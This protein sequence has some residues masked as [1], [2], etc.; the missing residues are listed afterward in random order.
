[1]GGALGGG[2][3]RGMGRGKRLLLVAYFIVN[4]IACH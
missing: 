2:E 1:M 3:L 4:P